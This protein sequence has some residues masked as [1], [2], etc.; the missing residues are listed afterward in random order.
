M[1]TNMRGLLS[2]YVVVAYVTLVVLCVFGCGVD[3]ET[4]S[5]GT[6]LQTEVIV[7]STTPD[8]E[9]TTQAP[10]PS[11]APT[12]SLEA[13]EDTHP[14]SQPSVQPATEET[15]GSGFDPE[16]GSYYYMDDKYIAEIIALMETEFVYLFGEDIIFLTPKDFINSFGEPIKKSTY[17]GEEWQDAN[18]V[19]VWVFS[20][21]F[22]INVGTENDR[23][24][25][26]NY[27]YLSPECEMK[28]STGVGIGDTSEEVFRAYGKLINH[29]LTTDEIIVIGEWRGWSLRFNISDNIVCSI[30]IGSGEK[31]S[32]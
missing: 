19:G 22:E 5:T 1:E 20:Q 28:L 30:Y 26:Q 21:G 24:I 25:V 7:V 9:P 15:T 29:K 13:Q 32:E 18:Q 3:A 23:P 17:K 27:L 16:V 2:I 6:S 14:T 12:A 4:L 31:Y 10:E 8:S 11:I